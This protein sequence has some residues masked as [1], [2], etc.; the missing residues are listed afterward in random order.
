[1]VQILVGTSKWIISKTLDFSMSVQF[2]LHA[3][4][5]S[6]FMPCRFL[7]S[8]GDLIDSF[9]RD[10]LYAVVFLLLGLILLLVILMI[11]E[12]PYSPLEAHL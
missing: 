1:M 9:P 6:C 4:D 3:T 5:C 12:E 8:C 2:G 10:C 7:C 11:H